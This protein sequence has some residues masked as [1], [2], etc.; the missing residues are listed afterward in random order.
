MMILGLTGPTGAGK[1]EAAR[2]FAAK[3][4]AVVDADRV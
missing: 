3:G 1:S 2:A 4:F